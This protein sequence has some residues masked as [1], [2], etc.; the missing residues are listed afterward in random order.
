MKGTREVLPPGTSEIGFTPQ[1]PESSGL[2]VPAAGRGVGRSGRR[3][4]AGWLVPLPTQQAAGGDAPGPQIPVPAARRSPCAL[5][6]PPAGRRPA[7]AGP[8]LR[9]PRTPGPEAQAAAGEGRSGPAAHRRVS[10]GG[11][12]TQA[13]TERS[14]SGSS[15]LL[16]AARPQTPS[17]TPPP[18]ALWSELR[19]CSHFRH[20]RRPERKC[21][22]RDARRQGWRAEPHLQL[23]SRSGR[24][25]S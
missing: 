12:T 18:W 19:P 4:L 23:A 8:A 17:P 1:D 11:D 2:P 5:R 22:S 15:R 3:R 16:G 9:S 13:A 6:P 10:G 21:L 24:V 20:R 14:D 7:W 25:R